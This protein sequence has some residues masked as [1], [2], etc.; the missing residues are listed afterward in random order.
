MEVE[1]QKD[2]NDGCFLQF[3][4]DYFYPFAFLAPKNN[5][6]FSYL[7]TTTHIFTRL[8][9][10]RQIRINIVLLNMSNQRGKKSSTTFCYVTSLTENIL[11]VLHPQQKIIL[12]SSRLLSSLHELSFTF[13][14]VSLACTSP[15]S[16]DTTPFFKNSYPLILFL[17]LKNSLKN[18]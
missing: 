1:R 9:V 12:S 4:S 2:Y 7:L 3:V 10:R 18:I 13:S 6:F 14:I 8:Q 16:S 15:L 17:F 5:Y 11:S